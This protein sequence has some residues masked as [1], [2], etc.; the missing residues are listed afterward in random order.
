MKFFKYSDNTT[1]KEESTVTDV[2]ICKNSL[3]VRRT[4]TYIINH[5]SK[6]GTSSNIYEKSKESVLK[7]INYLG[8]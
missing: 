5:Y 6:R 7:N 1:F 3:T 8:T 4:A 2:K